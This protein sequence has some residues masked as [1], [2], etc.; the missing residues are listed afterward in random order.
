LP[1]KLRR[2]AESHGDDIA[3]GFLDNGE[4]VTRELT[5]G[6]LDARANDVAAALIDRIGDGER[7]LLL[8]PPGLDFIIAFLGCLRAGRVA[9]PAIPPDPHKPA[10]SLARLGH[11]VD[12]ARPAA[13]L[14]T[15]AVS[16][17]RPLLDEAV[18][19][20]RSLP[21]IDV[22]EV[23]A[24]GRTVDDPRGEGL[25]FLQYTSGS[26]ATPKGV[27]VLRRNLTHNLGM[28]HDVAP[29]QPRSSVSWLPQF[30]D[31]GL[32][33]GILLPLHGGWPA[34]LMPPWAFLERPLR[35]L[36]AI[37][38]FSAIRSGGPNFAYDLCA[39]K[40]GAEARARLDLSCWVQA[41]CGSEPIHA[42]TLA[43]F[44]DAFGASGFSPKAWVPCYG[45]A[46]HTVLVTCCTHESFVIDR[47]S[48]AALG[49][50]EA[51]PARPDERGLDVVCSGNIPPFV[52]LHVID[53][54]TSTPLPDGRVGEIWLQSGSVTDGYWGHESGGGGTFD[55]MLRETPP[56]PLPREGL[57]S[58]VGS[59]SGSVAHDAML[60]APVNGHAGPFL[61]T[62]DLGYRRG[63]LLFV[64]GRSK[65][66]L[67]IRGVNHH[68]HDIEC[69]AERAHPAIRRGCVCAVM[70]DTS[71]GGVPAR[72][73]VVC[74]IAR[75][76]DGDARAEVIAAVRRAVSFEHGVS[77]DVVL[78][79]KHTVLKTSSGK[80][81][82]RA[83]AALLRDG[84][85]EG[86]WGGGS[87]GSGPA[88]TAAG[89][90]RRSPPTV[91]DAPEGAAPPPDD[92][93]PMTPA[94]A[95][96][97]RMTG[98]SIAEIDVDL[99][100]AHLPFDSLQA[101][102]AAAALGD[103]LGRGITLDAWGRAS[104]LRSLVGGADEG[105]APWI[106]D[107]DRPL[108][109]ALPRRRR[110]GVVLVTGGTGFVG[111]AVA[112]ELERRGRRVVVLARGA[113]A[114][115]GLAG[116][117]S[118]PGFGLPSDRF[119][120]LLDE[121]DVVIHAAGAVNWV[122]PYRSLAPANVGGT[123]EVISACAAAGAR[124]VH[125][126]S[127]I[128]CHD[129]AAA[130]QA[131]IDDLDEAPALLDR[132][133][134]LPLGYASSKAVAEILVS[135]ARDLGL[136]A[137]VVRPSLVLGGEGGE[138]S[139]DDVVAIVLRA[140]VE[141]GA[142]P[143]LDLPFAVCPR[144][145][146]T[147]VL[148]D[149]VD[150]GPPLVH[151][152]DESR[153]LRE[154][155][156]WLALAGYDIALTPWP[157]WLARIEELGLHR[158]GSLRGLWPFLRAGTLLQYERGRRARVLVKPSFQSAEPIDA[159]FLDQRVAAWQ[160][161]SLL[162]RPSRRGARAT[163]ASRALPEAPAQVVVDGELHRVVSARVGEALS[164]GGLL[165]CLATGFCDRPVGVYPAALTLD[166]GRTLDA[167][168]KA[169]AS[170]DEL[171]ALYRE[172]AR[173]SSPA[174]AAAL[175]QHGERLDVGGAHA[176]ERALYAIDD[177]ELR[178]QRPRCFSPRGSGDDAPLVLE[179]LRP[180]VQVEALDA[181]ASPWSLSS[182]R[183]AV[184]GIA[185]LHAAF[186]DRVLALEGVPWARPEATTAGDLV[187][188]WEAFFEQARARVDAGVTGAAAPL[189]ADV[190][191]ADAL[192][193]A[194]PTLLHNDLN[195]RNFALRP[196]EQGGIVL[197]DWELSTHGPAVRDL[198]ELL[199][200][201]LA[202]S[203]PEH[204]AFSLLRAHADVATPGQPDAELRAVFGAAL[205]W[206]FFDRL[207]NYTVGSPIYALPWHPR[208][209][210]TWRA[211]LG[212]FPPPR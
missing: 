112:R 34:W 85:I 108:L 204:E 121:L 211:L 198:A 152:G 169:S 122:L 117:V 39:R 66:V 25:A 54:E 23:P 149:V 165:S 209:L 187:P 64:V 168:L 6:A 160:A 82:R 50:G 186:R 80:L 14:S 146:L 78:V 185:R 135:R 47:V 83:M 174:L 48:V 72:P 161:A 195:P 155:V 86:V 92:D 69:V 179:R 203:T 142:A 148:A 207:T 178:G 17:F 106:V 59:G 173:A 74:E 107:L 3:V 115:G 197:Y 183:R 129:G 157:A 5:V 125:V 164:G 210:A 145:T 127:Q 46:E 60:S 158:R 191:W 67:I 79:P 170:G 126:S 190:G 97:A 120:A 30:H 182:V 95:L 94:R 19:A 77:V 133:P 151:V 101:V 180:G 147:R 192:S 131:V 163:P 184:A 49:R 138:V 144:D 194:P 114:S 156:A 90:P 44:A 10:R 206:L 202:P 199:C 29:F 150:A 172:V 88:G 1:S 137:T 56:Q 177:P 15:T 103:L 189:L 89:D 35:W 13:V 102:D 193:A 76:L 205:A 8:F 18:P 58:E 41:Y 110:G 27:R 68:A 124:L 21:W 33:E 175:L 98:L 81:Q 43:A 109:A 32:I 136:D 75:E 57:G 91:T 134:R 140:C 159:A 20:L 36:S 40:I 84:T 42:P 171:R 2:R 100:P 104:S 105:P 154:V 176:R 200:S 167:V 16:P 73:V 26:T 188:L 132:L 12:D 63:D 70:A 212:M 65:D 55:A 96:I 38:R 52:A 11:L 143:D 4:D 99:P 24:S 128:V 31:M 22:T 37:E 113:A 141:A 93:D 111:R 181:I 87:W 162:P 7:V 119:R 123:A 53:Q 9:V 196:G 130:P 139:H 61:R 166:D 118:L 51:R 71:S 116:D 28:I 201:T 62:G 208:V 153:T 45:L